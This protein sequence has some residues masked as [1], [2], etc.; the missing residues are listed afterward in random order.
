[1]GVF[2]KKAQR[3]ILRL[4]VFFQTRKK[5]EHVLGATFHKTTV[6]KNEKQF[7]ETVFCC[8]IIF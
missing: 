3:H 5:N 8:F 7:F 1:M 2:S 4:D 6:E